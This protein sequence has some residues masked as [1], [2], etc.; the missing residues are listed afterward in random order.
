[1]SIVSALDQQIEIKLY[2]REKHSKYGFTKIVVLEDEEGERLLR[3]QED[4][5]EKMQ[6]EGQQVTVADR[7]VKVL[8]TKWKILNWGEQNDIARRSERQT[9]EGLPDMDNIRFRD[10]R[11]KKCL[12]DWDL[13]DDHGQPIPVSPQLIDQLPSDIIFALTLRYERAVYLDEEEAEKN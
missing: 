6:T 2:Y 4:A 8:V 1:M 7:S 10:L 5:I 12:V 11:I 3:E 9:P 13:S